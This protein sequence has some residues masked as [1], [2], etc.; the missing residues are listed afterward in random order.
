MKNYI[1]SQSGR[2]MIEMLG[3]LAIVGVLS[4]AGIAGYSKAMAKYKTNRLIDQ[5]STVV[6]Y[7]QTRFAAQGNYKGCSGEV[8][9]HLGLYPEEATK[10]CDIDGEYTSSCVKNVFGGMLDV[11]ASDLSPEDFTVTVMNIPKDACSALAAMDWGPSF[12]S[13]GPVLDAENLSAIEK[14]AK[15]CS[16]NGKGDCL[17]SRVSIVFK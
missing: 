15:L 2:S 6:S 16:C 9:Y 7:T 12:V 3:V 5:I 4:V 1:S 10:Q 14:A 13:I 8:A 17:I 11:F